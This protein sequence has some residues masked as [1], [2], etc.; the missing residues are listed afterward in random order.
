MA[1]CEPPLP[2]V[3]ARLGVGTK[4]QLLDCEEEEDGVAELEED[5]DEDEEAVEAPGTTV[6]DIPALP[7]LP[8]PLAPPMVES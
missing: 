8:L 6:A 1:S 4:E 5:E 2:A 3:D 7:P